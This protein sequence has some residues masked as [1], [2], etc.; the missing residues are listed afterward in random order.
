MTLKEL[1]E[2]TSRFQKVAVYYGDSRKADKAANL[3][4]NL[5]SNWLESPVIEIKADRF[6]ELLVE[7]GD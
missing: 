3:L 4:N 5:S 2:K 7:V 1:L 6:S